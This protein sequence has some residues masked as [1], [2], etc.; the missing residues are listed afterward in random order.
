MNTPD[1]FSSN[2]GTL[3]G[4]IDGTNEN[5]AFQPGVVVPTTGPGAPHEPGTGLPNQIIPGFRGTTKIPST[6][7][8]SLLFLGGK[9][10]TQPLQGQT[11]GNSASFPS[12]P[13]PHQVVSV[14]AWAP[15]PTEINEPTLNLPQQFSTS[16]GLLLGAVNGSNQTFVLATG[17]LVTALL[18][19]WQGNFLQQ[20]A[21]FNWSCVQ[22]SSAGPWQTT[23]T[24][25]GGN[26]PAVGDVV[27]AQIFS[28]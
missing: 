5:F 8:A 16:N 7:V 24:M 19:W 26:V 21:Q 11:A 20:G 27:T 6:A 9:L 15:D 28:M 17:N 23:I 22:N 12:P 13:S 14:A 10:Q 18:L 25:I 3:T 2:A 1:E 4:P